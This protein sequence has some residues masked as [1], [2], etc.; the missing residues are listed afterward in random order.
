[1]TAE[2]GEGARDSDAGDPVAV[3]RG[4]PAAAVTWGPKVGLWSWSFVGAVVAAVIV[5]VALAAVS[6]IVLPLTFAAV[7]AVCFKPLAGRL[8][9][10]GVTSS[11]AAGMI[12]L[13][14]IALTT[15]IAV[16]AVRGSSSRRPRSGR[17]STPR[18]TSW[19]RRSRST[20]ARSTSCVRR[21]GTSRRWL[22]EV[23]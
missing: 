5:V 2:P 4:G 9:R 10:H 21:S 18:S 15:V 17:R 3:G 13:G 20:N 1:M 12:V 14:L 11:V 6:E 7:L 22:P 19:S 16:A 8:Q 23:S